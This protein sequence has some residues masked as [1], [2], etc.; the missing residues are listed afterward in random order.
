MSTAA[1]L[2]CSTR[3]DTHLIRHGVRILRVLLLPV[4][5]VVLVGVLVAVLL[6]QAG[7][8][9]PVKQVHVACSQ[10][11][12]TCRKCPSTHVP[13]TPAPHISADRQG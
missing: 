11:K 2:I 4:R 13:R 5:A 7:E 3:T 12:C 10:G 8:E 9:T 1:P 6:G